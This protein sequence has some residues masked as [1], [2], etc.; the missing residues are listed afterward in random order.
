MAETDQLKFWRGAFG[1]AYTDRC[2]VSADAVRGRLGVWAEMFKVMA[3]A[4]PAS[5][6]EVG[7]NEGINLHALSALTGA[8]LAAVE[9]NAAA[10]ERVKASGVAAAGD[11]VDGSAQ[12]L[13]FEDGAFDLVFT[14]GVLIHIHP[15]DLGAAVDEICRV[16]RRWVVCGEYFSPRPEALEYRGE[17]GYL[18]KRDFGKFYLDRH[19]ELVC[20]GYGFA[21][22]K[23]TSFDDITWQVFE[24]PQG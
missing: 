22:S 17:T 4:P 7:C 23:D 3:G 5:V 8:R 15:D 10:R 19:P 2:A 18:F 21:W 16:S 1:D 20:R 11:I 6:L 24:K 9:P 13:P 14:T 12:A